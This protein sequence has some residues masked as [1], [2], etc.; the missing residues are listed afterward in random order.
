MALIDIRCPACDRIKEV[1]RAVADWPQ[2]PPCANCGGP[3]E[4]IHLPSATRRRPVD[5]VVVYQAPDGTFRFPPDITSASTAMYDQQGMTRI[6]LRDWADVRRFEHHFNATEMSQVH[7]RL[8]RQQ[9]AHER[10]EKER[11]TEARRC[12]EQGFRIPE[13]DDR[14]VPTGRLQ[15]VR[16]TPKGRA[17]LEAAQRHNDAKGGPRA[18]EV[19]F[20]I[21]AYS[22]DRSN[23]DS[24]S[25]GRGRRSS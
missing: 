12:L 23:R 13:V 15:T 2:T 5:P 10:A 20:H 21:E 1:V 6:E 17:I 24:Y 22:D 4:Q 19:G 18:K 9:E 25:D 14:G 7:R 11:R 8:E 16:L 3:T